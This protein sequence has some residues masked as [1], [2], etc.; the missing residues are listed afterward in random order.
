METWRFTKEVLNF[1]QVSQATDPVKLIKSPEA[2]GI[3][4]ALLQEGK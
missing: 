3:F 2:D 1:D 4:P